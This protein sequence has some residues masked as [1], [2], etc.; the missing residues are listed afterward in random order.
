M[1]NQVWIA[2]LCSQRH[3]NK[4]ENCIF[5]KLGREG[6][7]HKVWE[8]EKFLAFLDIHPAQ[9]GHTLLIPKKHDDYIFD[10]SDDEYTEHFLEAKK[11]AKHLKE[12]LN[13]KRIGII[14][15]GFGVSHIHVHLIPIN[16]PQEIISGGKTVPMQELDEILKKLK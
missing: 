8:S 9:P 7:K 11:V 12:K 10:L 5:C 1:A 2:S 4:M 16:N 3:D 13:S 6:S 15:E 14:V